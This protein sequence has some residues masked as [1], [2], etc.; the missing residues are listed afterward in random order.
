[1]PEALGGQAQGHGRPALYVASFDGDDFAAGDAVVGTESEPGGKIF[2]RGKAG[3]E[4]GSQFGEKDQRGADLD[5]GHFRQVHATEPV[6]FGAG[7]ETRFVALRLFVAS[8][9]G[10]QRVLV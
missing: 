8:S 2:G 5:T 6:E 9:V 10:G 4:V 1:M 3:D 7:I